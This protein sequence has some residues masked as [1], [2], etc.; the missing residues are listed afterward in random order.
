MLFRGVVLLAD[1]LLFI[2]EV[3]G[4]GICFGLCAYLLWILFVVALILVTMLFSM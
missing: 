3:F 4:F 1:A 2:V